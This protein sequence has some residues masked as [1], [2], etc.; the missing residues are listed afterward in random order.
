MRRFGYPPGRAIALN[1]SRVARA[2]SPPV[3]LL[4]EPVWTIGEG[5][6][7]FNEHMVATSGRSCC[8]RGHAR[9]SSLELVGKES[10]TRRDGGLHGSDE[11][12]DAA[13]EHGKPAR[14]HQFA[15]ALNEVRVEYGQRGRVGHR[16]D[17]VRKQR[18]E[19]EERRKPRFALLRLT[20]PCRH[21]P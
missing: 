18:P 16:R 21:D 2:L 19:P 11:S 4:R 10:A 6:E 7:N 3:S 15:L 1:E 9:S 8:V 14:L 12:I 17:R 5:G 13:V 20:A